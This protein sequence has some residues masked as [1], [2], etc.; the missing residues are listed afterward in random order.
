[1]CSSDEAAAARAGHPLH[2]VRD[3]V[4]RRCKLGSA[5]PCIH[6]KQSASAPSSTMSSGSRLKLLSKVQSLHR[7]IGGHSLALRLETEAA[8]GLFFTRNPDVPDG[9]F[10]GVSHSWATPR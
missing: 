1:M 8:F 6:D 9:V 7:A 4:L 10:H 2:F 3:R 5:F